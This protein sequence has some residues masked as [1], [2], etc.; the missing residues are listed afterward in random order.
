[1]K[2][3]QLYSYTRRAIDDYQMID[4]GDKIAVGIS[5]GKDSLTLLYALHGLKRFYPQKFELI[6]ITVNLGYQEFD[7]A[8]L[9]NLCEK[10]EIPYEE[11]RTDI[12]DIV[13]QKNPKENP[14]SLCAKLR[15]GA[16]NDAAK[17]LGCNKVAYA[18]HKDDI[19]ETMVL[20]LIFEGRFHSF[21]PKTYLDRTELTVIR[22]MMYLSE[23][24]VIGFKNRMNLPVVKNPCPVDGHTK[25]QYAKDLLRQLNLDHPGTKDRMF[26]AIIN[27]NIA[28][29]P[30]KNPNPK[31]ANSYKTPRQPD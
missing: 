4:S 20:S 19:I 12:G 31:Y 16:L 22:P 29:W 7:V 6:A 1:M 9:Q 14:C 30:P 27:G 10:L 5:G 25:R 24:D 8:P 21:S 11:V 23:A 26:T 15:K 18:H 17:R 2:L 28:G 13:F 3:Q